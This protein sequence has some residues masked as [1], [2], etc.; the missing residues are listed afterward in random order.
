MED[1]LQ[2][3]FDLHILLLDDRIFFSDYF[4]KF[5]NLC[6]QFFQCHTAAPVLVLLLIIIAYFNEY[7]K[8]LCPKKGLKNAVFS[9]KTEAFS[10]ILTGDNF[11]QKQVFSGEISTE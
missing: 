8:L 6:L 11:C 4:I 3:V 5:F 1:R 7:Q 10:G 2:H 9:R